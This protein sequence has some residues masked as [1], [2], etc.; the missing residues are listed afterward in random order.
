MSN[1]KWRHRLKAWGLTVSELSEATKKELKIKGGVKV[2][3][4]SDAAERAGLR[5]GDVII[6]VANTELLQSKI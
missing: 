5:E 2:D 3:S 6:S 4:V 1:R